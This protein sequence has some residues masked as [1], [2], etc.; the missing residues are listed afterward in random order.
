ML[1]DLIIVIKFNATLKSILDEV[2]DKQRRLGE[3]E[4]FIQGTTVYHARREE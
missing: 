4:V 2:A 3:V 1:W